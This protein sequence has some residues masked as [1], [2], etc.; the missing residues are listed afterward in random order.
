MK[1]SVVKANIAGGVVRFMRSND[2]GY[3]FAK[4]QI[5]YLRRKYPDVVQEIANDAVLRRL[6]R[7]ER[8][9]AGAFSAA[10]T[11]SVHRAAREADVAPG[12]LHVEFTRLTEF[13]TT[14]QRTPAK[15][16][17]S[18]VAIAKEQGPLA[19]ARSG[20]PRKA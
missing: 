19:P 16:V 5:D 12:A 3:E 20:R 7:F 9:H 18:V 11:S 17:Q 8:R 13:A 14:M 10:L 1:R 2:C 6:V 4:R 15:V